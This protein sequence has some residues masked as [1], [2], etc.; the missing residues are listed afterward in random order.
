MIQT[1]KINNETIRDVLIKEHGNNV[2]L[3]Y[4]DVSRVTDMCSLLVVL[5][6]MVILV[7]GMSAT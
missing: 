2:D 7:I 3:N 4:L 1:I 5:N 6:S